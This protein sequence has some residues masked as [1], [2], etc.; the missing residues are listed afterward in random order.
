[1]VHSNSHSFA[2]A[3]FSIAKEEKEQ[4]LFYQQAKQLVDIN[5]ECSDFAK[6]LSSRS[7][8]KVERKQVANDVL[9]ELGFNQTFIYWVWTIIDANMYGF[10]NE[11]F[12]EVKELHDSLFNIVSIEIISASD[13]TDTQISKIQ[14]FFATKLNKKIELVVKID[15]SQIGGLEIKI[16]NKTYSNTFKQQLQNLKQKLKSRKG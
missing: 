10:Y 14:N 16:S 15:P 12:K 8:S 4:E 6:L 13:L 2:T 11:I 9:K 5:N 7:I 1:M 3:L